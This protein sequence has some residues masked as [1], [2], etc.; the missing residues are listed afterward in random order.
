[1]S[2]RIL[3]SSLIA[4]ISIAAATVANAPIASAADLGGEGYYAPRDSYDYPPRAQGY[5][6][7]YP[8]AYVP[9]D[10]P[11]EYDEDV[12]PPS[13]SYREPGPAVVDRVGSYAPTCIPRWQ[14]RNSL[15]RD[16][17][18]DLQPIDRG[19]GVVTVRARREFS[20]R[21]FLLDVDRCSGEIV[22][23]RPHFLRPFGDGSRPR[24]SRL[25]DPLLTPSR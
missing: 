23:A 8:P 18:T 15:H 22:N 21:V 5:G 2:A 9:R 25:S 13:S 12:P 7:P 20:G 19:G 10:A 24:W 6:E 1:M 14:I 11:S 3:R 4:V 17:W 16:G